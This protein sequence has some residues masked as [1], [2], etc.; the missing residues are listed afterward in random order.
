MSQHAALPPAKAQPTRAAYLRM[1]RRLALRRI[2]LAACL[3]GVA[4]VS[5]GL[6]TGAVPTSGQTSVRQ[7]APG[8]LD[9]VQ[10]TARASLDWQTF[11][12]TAGERVNIAQPD[13]TSVLL[14]RDRKS[15]V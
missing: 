5:F 7:T 8:Q 4:P 15:V 11:S 13:R 6:P 10:S 1:P 14:N 3:L 2:S 12:I 9:I